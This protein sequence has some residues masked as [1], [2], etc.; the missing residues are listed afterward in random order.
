MTRRT[1]RSSRSRILPSRRD[2]FKEGSIDAQFDRFSK[3]S[4]KFVHDGMLLARYDSSQCHR[5]AESILLRMITTIRL[6]QVVSTAMFRNER[7]AIVPLQLMSS[8][9]RSRLDIFYGICI[10]VVLPTRLLLQVRIRRR[11]SLSIFRACSLHALE[12]VPDRGGQIVW[13]SRWP[14]RAL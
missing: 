6:S 7:R 5:V 2:I 10:A 1:F 3:K 11:R 4:I 14:S 12:E 9:T 8:F 13:R